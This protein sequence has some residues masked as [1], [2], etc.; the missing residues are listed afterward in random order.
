LS[1]I[2]QPADALS[3]STRRQRHIVTVVIV[4][5]DGARLIPGL[6][7]GIAE[8]TYP[9]ARAIGVDTG[10]RDRSGALLA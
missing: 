8:Q 9:V 10:S 1:A 6:V 5:H 7:Q 3:Q 2:T 4:T